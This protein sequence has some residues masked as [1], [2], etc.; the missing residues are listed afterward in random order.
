MSKY[1]LISEEQPLYDGGPTNRCRITFEF[2]ADT[3]ADVISHFE[4]FL[5]GNG[6]QISGYLD[7]V[8]DEVYDSPKEIDIEPETDDL[9]QDSWP[10]QKTESSDTVEQA[11][12]KVCG[13][14]KQQLS[15]HPCYDKK[16]GFKFN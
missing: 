1:T 5:R 10:F 9:N 11:K 3:L 4:D 13:L 16:C 8:S 15:D 12:C 7:I 14:T 6:F 2:Q